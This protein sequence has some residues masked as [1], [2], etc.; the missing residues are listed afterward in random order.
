MEYTMDDQGVDGK[1]GTYAELL[2]EVFGGIEV[3]GDEYE[4]L[5][6]LLE[7]E[8]AEEIIF[9]TEEDGDYTKFNLILEQ[10]YKTSEIKESEVG[11]GYTL[12]EFMGVRLV[13]TGYPISI[14][15]I[16]TCDRELFD[17]VTDSIYPKIN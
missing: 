10:I 6:N 15:F 4:V 1:K 8:T 13:V 9:T 3:F 12:Y 7:V 16:K 14:I 17:S 11:D 5:K 2:T